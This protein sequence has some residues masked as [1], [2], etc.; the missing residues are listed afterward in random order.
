MQPQQ[1]ASCAP[2]SGEVTEAAPTEDVAS[3]GPDDE[4][5]LQHPDVEGRGGG[6]GGLVQQ[7]DAEGDE[8]RGAYSRMTSKR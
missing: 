1:A 3:R 7:R 4:E 8:G 2:G 5:C 6:G